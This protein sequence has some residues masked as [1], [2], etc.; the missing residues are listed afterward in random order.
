[1]LNDN[2][3]NPQQDQPE[4]PANGLL[5]N[6]EPISTPPPR[7]DFAGSSLPADAPPTTGAGAAPPTLQ[8]SAPEAPLPPPVAMPAHPLPMAGHKRRKKGL[9]IG[10]IA[11]VLCLLLSAAAAASYY[12]IQVNKPEN[13]L[14]QALANSLDLSKFKTVAFSGASDSTYQTADTSTT[15]SFQ[16]AFDIASGAFTVSGEA[17]AFLTKVTYDARSV[18]GK[19]L[20]FRVGGL[21]GLSELLANSEAGAYAPFIATVNNQWFEL[22]ESLIK[23]YV[24]S[25]KSSVLTS[26][27]AQKIRDAYLQHSFLVIKEVLP[28]QAVQ[29]K[30]HYHY[31]LVISAAELKAFLTALKAAGPESF[32]LDQTMLD[33]LNR[34]IDGEDLSKFPFEFWIAKDDKLINQVAFKAAESGMAVSFRFTVDSYNQP[35]KVEKPAGAKSLLELLSELFGP[36]LN[37]SPLTPAEGIMSL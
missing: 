2:P 10:L 21:D 6:A 1:M 33:A 37:L 8:P 32:Q 24:P 4:Q 15:A 25:Y 18:D 13:I 16:G 31:K 36:D 28:D 17:D 26:A 3:M 20:Y 30:P 22:N 7:A 35:V 9:V 34:G 11:A 19:S 27:D 29:G 12:Y 14:K 5:S 23:Q